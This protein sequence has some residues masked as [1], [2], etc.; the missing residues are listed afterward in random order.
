M[1]IGKFP[2]RA[3]VASIT[4]SQCASSTGAES[5]TLRRAVMYGKSKLTVVTARSTIPCA[6]PVMNGLV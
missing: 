6:N 1:K 4:L 3:R 5:G 2:H